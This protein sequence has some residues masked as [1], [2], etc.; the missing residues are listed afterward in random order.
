MKFNIQYFNLIPKFL[1]VLLLLS[2][3]IG[4]AQE[5]AQ[6]SI[7]LEISQTL[8]EQIRNKGRLYVF[9]TKNNN[10][11]PR[12]QLFPNPWELPKIFA[13]NLDDFGSTTSLALNESLDWDH[14]TNHDL[15]SIPK[16]KYYIQVLW[17]QD[18]KESRINAPGNLFTTPEQIDLNKDLTIELE[19]S[20]VIPERQLI[21]HELVREVNFKSDTLSKWWKKTMEIKA[22]ILLPSD[23]D[24]NASYP[25]RYNVAGYGGRYTRIENIIKDKDFM[26]WWASEDSPQVIN[27]FLDGEGPFGDPYQMDSDNSGPFG[28][29]LIY[30]LIPHIEDTYRNS[31]SAKTRFVDGCSTGGWVSLG[32]QIFYPDH[33]NGAFSYSPD[34][35]EFENYQLINIYKDQK[36]YTNEFGYLRPCMRN[37]YGEPLQSMKSF[38]EFENV[39]GYSGTYLDSGDQFGSHTA[40]YS[41][42]GKNGLPKPLFDPITGVIDHEVAEYWKKYDLK[43]HLKNNWETLGEKLQGKIYI[44][45][46]DMDHFYLNMATR[47]FQKFLE[48][49]EDPKSDAVIE[50]TPM[51]GHCSY[52]NHRKVL[53]QIQD[54]LNKIK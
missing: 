28:Y 9:L 1:T 13:V 33:F 49:T 47:E 37:T 24:K 30:E 52:F 50:F 8:K 45:M 15:S 25:I 3:T 54:R 17:D 35:I 27:V 36:A 48:T 51:Q 29:A 46:G 53:E 19:L 4:Q 5:T 14:T 2:L 22:S 44:W 12:F 20:E 11:E 16:N 23:Y 43:L 21:E 26:T 41:P 18:F 39:Q 10:Q 7:N 38:V 6:L 34:A 40:L 32:L 31:N 42:K